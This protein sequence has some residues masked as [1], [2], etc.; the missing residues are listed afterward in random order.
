M[1]SRLLSETLIVILHSVRV[2]VSM[3]DDV[4]DDVGVCTHSRAN[5]LELP[6]QR[7]RKSSKS[8]H[9]PQISNSIESN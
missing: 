7:I 2:Q 5:W 3:W 1:T 8:S 4:C 6:F 9:L